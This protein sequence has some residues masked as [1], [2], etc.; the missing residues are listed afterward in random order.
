MVAVDWAVVVP[1]NRPEKFREFY[2]LWEPLFIQHNVHLVVVEDGPKHSDLGVSLDNF[3][4][5]N[6]DDVPDFIPKKTDMIR[7]WGFYHVYRHNISSYILTLDD[8]VEPVNDVFE[9]YA[10]QFEKGSTFSDYLSVGALTTSGLEMRGYPYRYRKEAPVGV[11]YGGWAGVLDY[12]AATQL[13]V[14]MPP[15]DFIDVVMPVPKGVATTCCIMNLAFRTELT[16][17]MWQLT[18]LDGRYNRIGDIWSGLIIKKVLDSIGAV[19]LI[20]GKAMVEHNRASDPY[21]SLAKEAPSVY[22]NDHLWD[23]LA[24]P[25]VNDIPKAHKEVMESFISFVGEHDPEYSQK[26][27]EDFEQWLSLFRS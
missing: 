3:T 22:I 24:S 21:N 15:Q 8:D 1:T 27:R 18:M 12:D 6:W 20:N 7:S 26:T 10:E 16:P 9:E 13:A 4:H 25:S 14:P 5:L 23:N 17:I 19:M 2:K 11:Q